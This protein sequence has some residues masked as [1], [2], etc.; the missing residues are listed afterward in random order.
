M[1]A[2]FFVQP[3]QVSNAQ[4]MILGDDVK[5]ATRVLR[6]GKG[7][8]VTVLDGTGNE[9]Q[10]QLVE[11]GR[12]RL[13][14]QIIARTVSSAEPRHRLTVVQGL[15]KGDKLEMVIQKCTELGAIA[16]VPVQ[17]ERSVVQLQAD[18]VARKQERW[19]RIAQEA[20]EQSRRGR[21]PVVKPAVTWREFWAS[22]DQFDLILVAWEEEMGMSLHAVL[23][24]HPNAAHIALVIG[25]EGGI[26]SDEIALARQAGAKTVTLG[27]R[28]LRTETAGV[29]LLSMV[30]YHYG[31]MG[32]V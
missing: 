6:L 31:E 18:K 16:F 1:V 14:G 11:L 26:S 17:M 32:G 5:H 7:D 21:V 25:P 28:I 4:V 10:A 2:R 9:Y 8:V 30:M 29:A 27:Q 3:E 15:P 13:I 23:G 22:S 20:A 12:E 24:Q 19:Q